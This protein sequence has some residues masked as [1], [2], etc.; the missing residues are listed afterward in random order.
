MSAQPRVSAPLTTPLTAAA[1]SIPATTPGTGSAVASTASGGDLL[2]FDIVSLAR[3]AAQ[4]RVKQPAF[5]QTGAGRVSGADG[6]PSQPMT[7]E[8]FQKLVSLYAGAFANAG[9]QPGERILVAGCT[10]VQSIAAIIA[11]LS[12]GADAALAGMH[13]DSSEIAAFA[14]ITGASAIVT[15]AGED[16]TATAALVLGA[17]AQ[18]DCVRLVV[19]LADDPADGTVSVS[20]AAGG[21]SQPPAH[22]EGGCI[23]TRNSTGMPV[24]HS[25]QTL[26]VAGLDFLARTR[27]SA[28]APIVTT[29]IPASF[30]GLVCGPLAGLLLGSLTNLHAPFDSAV[31]VR[32]IEA[33]KPVQMVAPAALATQIAA[34]G[35][36]D[37]DHLSALVLLNRYEAAPP[38]LDAP[39]LP[40][41]AVRGIAVSDLAAFDEIAV[42]AQLRG[43]DGVPVKP[44]EQNHMIHIDG[45]EVLALRA[46]R[47]LLENNGVRSTAMTFD[48]AAVSRLDWKYHDTAD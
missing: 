43:A 19:S 6:E 9:V 34:S 40:P 7:F 18:A 12:I 10:S 25:Q 1:E 16:D 29:I 4:L 35:F 42:A 36:C 46:V 2:G 41:L 37:A 28:G 30:A 44:L 5:I 23:I 15:D 13:L 39:A 27:L 32:T 33:S 31:L 24:T 21:G 8:A 48:G 14:M 17:A 47:H 20:A 3:S 11:T 22:I 45:R 26:I 38:A